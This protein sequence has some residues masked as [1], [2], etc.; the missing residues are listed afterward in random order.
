[1]A[2][3]RTEDALRF[4]IGLFNDLAWIKLGIR[5][6]PGGEAVT[7]LPQAQLAIDAIGALAPL[8]EGHL[9]AHEVRDLKNLL[10][11]LQMNYVQRK[12]KGEERREKGK[13]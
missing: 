12:V 13:E 10:T 11:S 5:A 8:S 3:M 4:A 1:M 7:D 6:V 9:E 2:E